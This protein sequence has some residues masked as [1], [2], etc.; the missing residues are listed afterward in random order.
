MSLQP[1]TY[2]DA[3]Q[4]ARCRVQKPR[5]PLTPKS[6]LKRSQKPSLRKRTPKRKK[7]ATRKSLIRKID[8]LVFEFVQVRDGSCVECGSIEK[9]TTGHVLSRR[10]FATRWDERNVHLQCWPH[11]YR[12]AM[13]AAAAYHLWFVKKFG[14]DA[15]D[16]LYRD[17]VKGRKFTRLE[18]ETVL[19]CWKEKVSSLKWQ[20]GLPQ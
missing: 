15:F 14:V 2:E 10:S 18:L 20:K 5:R 8:A 13:T 3:L 12:A 1:A 11:N 4:K 6:T 9:P 19:L 7:V 16:E 17:W